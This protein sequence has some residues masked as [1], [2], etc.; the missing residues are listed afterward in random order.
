MK[1]IEQDLNRIVRPSVSGNDKKE[2]VPSVVLNSLATFVKTGSFIDKKKLKK[3]VSIASKFSFDRDV[4]SV[5]QVDDEEEEDAERARAKEYP[6]MDDSPPIPSFVPKNYSISEIPEE[7]TFEVEIAEK[8]DSDGEID[9]SSY[10]R[11]TAPVRKKSS[12]QEPLKQHHRIK[13]VM[14]RPTALSE[15]TRPIV[16]QSTSQR[17]LSSRL[18]KTSKHKTS[19]TDDFVDLLAS[20]S[21][22]V[23]GKKNMEEIRAPATPW[24]SQKLRRPM[25]PLQLQKSL[26]IKDDVFYDLEDVLNISLPVVEEYQPE[27]SITCGYRQQSKITRI[28][29]GDSTINDPVRT[30]LG[31]KISV[32]SHSSRL[33]DRPAPFLR[34]MMEGELC[35]DMEQRRAEERRNK[36]ARALEKAS[37]KVSQSTNKRRQR[38]IGCSGKMLKISFEKNALD[39]LEPSIREVIEQGSDERIWFTTWVSTIQIIVYIF[40][41]FLYEV[42]PMMENEYKKEVWDTSATIRRVSYMEQGNIW[43]GPRYADL[44]HLGAKYSPCMRKEKGLW[45]V[46]EEDKRKEDLT[47]CCIANDGSCY[48]ASEKVCPK[49]IARWAGRSTRNPEKVLRK[50]KSES[51]LLK[52]SNLIPPGRRDLLWSHDNNDVTFVCGQDPRFCDFPRSIEPHVWSKNISDWPICTKPHDRSLPPHMTCEISGRPCCIQLQ[53]LCRIT[54]KEYCDFVNCFNDVCGMLPFFGKY[55]DQFYR[56]FFSLFIHGGLIH[57]FLTLMFQIYFMRDLEQLIGSTRM[58]IVY[59]ASGVGG[60]LVSAILVPYSPSVGPFGSHFGIL[61]AFFIDIYHH[62]Q[63]IENSRLACTKYAIIVVV[64]FFCGLFPWVDNWTHI[65]GFW[66]GFHATIVVFPYLDF[67]NNSNSKGKTH[68]YRNVA[69]GAISSPISTVAFAES[70]NVISSPYMFVNII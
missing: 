65:A 20:K 12:V 64:L 49:E 17:K 7:S 57:L 59:I 6:F 10:S 30:E 9:I 40:S 38:G 8:E 46:I 45:N 15:G 48:Q 29:V 60:N 14:E 22:S 54:T 35:D 52:N 50:S 39:Q 69:P 41:L 31:P 70:P 44:V 28:D 33:P 19:A 11:M 32:A 37:A 55:P 27:A 58:A 66:F 2:S 16:S 3:Q 1:F 56:L 61:A 25:K 13:E 18:S 26:S 36:L 5:T 21:E 4:L 51:D 43:I 68:Q 63:I 62:R 24:S 34:D 47:G 42:A 23:D 53:G 67:S